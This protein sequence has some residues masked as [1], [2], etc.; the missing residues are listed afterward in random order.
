MS[1]QTYK[2]VYFNGKNLA[3]AFESIELV[4]AL[5]ELKKLD[6]IDPF[7]VFDDGTMDLQ[8]LSVE[9]A[10]SNSIQLVSPPG[11]QLKSVK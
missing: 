9:A 4:A 6:V 8:N 3:V 5:E 11:P 1:S 7:V 10:K 2:V